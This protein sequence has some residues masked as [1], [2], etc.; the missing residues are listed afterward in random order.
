V[1]S[2]S[3]VA[4]VLVFGLV[5]ALNLVAITVLWDAA[6]SGGHGLTPNG[7][8]LLVGVLTGVT[9]LLGVFIGAIVIAKLNGGDD[10]GWVETAR[11]EPVAQPPSEKVTE[12]A[13][14]SDWPGPKP[15]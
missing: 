4:L 6:S 13:P 12:R 11:Y 1:G 7:T 3:R 10:G 9:A 2:N 15:D 14:T 8:A 5:A